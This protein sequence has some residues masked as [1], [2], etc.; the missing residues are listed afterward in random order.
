MK[1]KLLIN[2]APV[3]FFTF[4]N[5]LPEASNNYRIQSNIKS[6][7]KFILIEFLLYDISRSDKIID[8]DIATS[9]EIQQYKFWFNFSFTDLHIG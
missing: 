5:N 4:L 9:L 7:A 3:S 2:N 6:R 8:S 1:A